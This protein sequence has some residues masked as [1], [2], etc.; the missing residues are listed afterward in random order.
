MIETTP[1]EILS[2]PNVFLKVLSKLQAGEISE[3]VEAP[4]GHH[5]FMLETRTNE[6]ITFRRLTVPFSFS[7]EV[8]LT[9]KDKMQEVIKKLN[10]DESFVELV[11][12]YSDDIE[13]KDNGGNLGIHAINELNPSIRKIIEL[14]EVGNVSEPLETELGLHIYK[15]EDRKKPEL[16][17]QE[18]QQI[19][20]ILRQQLFEKEWTAY[21]DSLLV[22]AYIK[23]KPDAVPSTETK[24]D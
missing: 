1:A 17:P 13:T 15:V 7:E 23:I 6:K 4:D 14:L 20:G 22:N 16:T 21:T 3:P 19:I 5:V 18:K 11:K 2:Y 10:A 12:L 9:A 24:S 8:I